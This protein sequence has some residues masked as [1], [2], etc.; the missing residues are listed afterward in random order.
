MSKYL[1]FPF[2]N[3]TSTSTF[4]RIVKISCP[5]FASYPKFPTNTTPADRNY[6]QLNSSVQPR[7]T[8]P[9]N[10]NM[11]VPVPRGWMLNAAEQSKHHPAGWPELATWRHPGPR[12]SIADLFHVVPATKSQTNVVS[13]SPTGMKHVSDANQPEP[14]AT[15]ARIRIVAFL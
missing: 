14:E 9:P 13:S 12:P 4:D 6:K 3:T 15:V 10:D 8:T 7:C 5:P 2:C 11:S 1:L